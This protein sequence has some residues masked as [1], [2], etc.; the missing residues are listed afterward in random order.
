MLGKIIQHVK[1]GFC[2]IGF[3]EIEF[4]GKKKNIE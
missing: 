4:S 3:R 2:S 1:Y